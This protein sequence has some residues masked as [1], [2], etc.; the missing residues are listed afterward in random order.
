LRE[1]VKANLATH[2]KSEYDDG[3]FA[4]LI[5]KIKEIRTMRRGTINEQY[6]KVPRKEKEPSIRGPYYVLSR[7]EGG[8][9]VGFR[10]KTQEELDLATKDVESYKE[11]NRLSK[12]FITVTESITDMIRSVEK[13]DSK[14]NKKFT[15]ENTTPK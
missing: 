8:K 13:A 9:T 5:E 15:K 6:L 10:L 7:N 3:Y 1:A 4:Q 2:S 14:K 12:E 11:F